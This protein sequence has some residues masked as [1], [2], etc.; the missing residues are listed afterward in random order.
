MLFFHTLHLSCAPEKGGPLARIWQGFDL[1]RQLLDALSSS[2]R[3]KKSAIWGDNR[4]LNGM[5]ALQRL[6]WD[7]FRAHTTVITWQIFGLLWD[8]NARVLLS[9]S[10]SSSSEKKYLK[11]LLFCRP[12]ESCGA[13]FWAK[14]EGTDARS[15]G[16]SLFF[17]L[18]CF[19]TNVLTVPFL[20]IPVVRHV[21]C[22][23]SGVPKSGWTCL[24]GC[25]YISIV[26]EFSRGD[27]KRMR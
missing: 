27:A 3:V 23:V 1:A 16:K 11:A 7:A 22:T 20:L 8:R 4:I 6:N 19:S 9:Q 18:G 2:Y 10:P 12:V 15:L 14:K 13:K 5:E 26:F 17:P 25:Y 24:K 21:E